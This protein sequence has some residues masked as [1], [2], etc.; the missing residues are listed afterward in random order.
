M[1][2]EVHLYNTLFES[3]IEIIVILL[4]TPSHSF[5]TFGRDRLA[6]GALIRIASDND[7]LSPG[8]A[9]VCAADMRV[10]VDG[11]ATGSRELSTSAFRFFMCPANCSLSAA[12]ACEVPQHFAYIGVCIQCTC[13]YKVGARM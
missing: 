9:R 11:T 3:I 6:C 1:C 4:S 7:V 2:D 10:E 12:H 13:V 8:L 5:E